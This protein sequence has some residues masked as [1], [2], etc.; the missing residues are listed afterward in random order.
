AED[1]GG[2]GLRGPRG[3]Q[4]RGRARPALHRPAPGARGHQPAGL[5]RAPGRR[6]HRPPAGPDHGHRGPQRPD[7]GHP[8]PHRRPGQ[9]GAGGGV[10]PQRGRVRHPA[11]PDGRPRPGHRARHR[12][13]A[14]PDPAGHDH[15]L[16]GQP[17]LHPRCLRRAGLRHRHQRGRARAGH[18]DAAAAAG[19]A[20]GGHGG[21]RAAPGGLGEGRHPGRHRPDR[22]QWRAG[23]RHRVPGQR[24]RGAVD[25]GADDDLQH[26]HRGRRARR[27]D[28]PRP[29]DVR[30]PAGPPA[31]PAGRRLGRS[32][33]A[34]VHAAHRPRRRL[35]PRGAH[36]R[37]LAEPLRHLGH[38]PRPGPADQRRRARPGADRR[39]GRPPG[40]R[41][42]AGLHGADRRYTA[43]RDRRGH[44]VPG[45]VHQQPDRGPADGRRP[46]EGQEGRRQHP[47]A[48]RPG[49][50]GGQAAGRG[51]GA[52][53]GL[54]RRRSRVARRGL[55]DVPGHEPRPAA[56][57][58]A[59]G[60]HQQPQLPGPAGQGRAHPPG[61]PGRRRRDRAHRE[62]HRPGRP[63]R[64]PRR[65]L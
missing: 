31:R 42:G 15:R 62:A 3:A 54:H 41:V 34:L 63:P 43:A 45:V 52:G 38:Q 64:R 19:P 56:A 32:R 8:E 28:R 61:L 4:R 48:R 59:V 13:A 21:R 51:R 46:A 9:P 39:R 60:L 22:H 58:R 16:R 40:G 10:A 7:A 53:P 26:V 50:G 30:V 44:G 20:D 27:A 11:G 35:R 1:P 18:P 25:G 33:G 36:R 37:R 12:P 6:A 2:E 24:D 17:H 23:T 65:R 47:D 57:R 29:D 49:V 14:G 55:L 5:R